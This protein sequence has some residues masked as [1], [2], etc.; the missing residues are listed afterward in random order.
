MSPLANFFRPDPNRPGKA[1]LRVVAVAYVF[2]F[3]IFL[4]LGGEPAYALFLLLVPFMLITS[5]FVMSPSIIIIGFITGTPGVSILWAW[6]WCKRN[7]RYFLTAVLGSGIL[8]A[9]IF[10]ILKAAR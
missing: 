5:A 7:F 10:L 9:A 1:S 2:S 6:R 3:P 8:A 4:M